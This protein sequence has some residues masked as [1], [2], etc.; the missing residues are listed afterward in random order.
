MVK[1][2]C[3]PSCRVMLSL[4]SSVPLTPPTPHATL[5]LTSS[6]D[7]YKLLPCVDYM[8]PPSV[9]T[10][11]FLTF[12]YPYTERWYF[13]KAW[14]QK[15]LLSSPSLVRLDIFVCRSITMQQYSLY[16]T[17]CQFAHIKVDYFAVGL[18]LNF[19]HSMLYIP[20]QH[21]PLLVQLGICYVVP[22]WLLRQ[23]FHLQVYASLAGQ[24]QD[25]RP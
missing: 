20:L 15:Y 7:L 14:F 4:Q 25:T 3:L 6:A 11:T 8:G 12:R 16:V 10:Q 5:S 24:W 18:Q 1:V 19:R 21:A 23:D 9:P 2:E 17:D 13:H 22:R